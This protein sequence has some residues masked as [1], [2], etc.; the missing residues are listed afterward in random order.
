MLKGEHA[1]TF[2]RSA[3]RIL[4]SKDDP[5]VGPLGQHPTRQETDILSV[6]VRLY[7]CEQNISFFKQPAP[8]ILGFALLCVFGL[9][10][11]N[12]TEECERGGEER[13]RNTKTIR[14]QS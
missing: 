2:L 12:K 10:R 8:S 11:G 1:L 5:F 7:D 6:V 13:V 4:K 9:L 14:G 3:F